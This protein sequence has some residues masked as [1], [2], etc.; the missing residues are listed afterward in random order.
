MEEKA[1]SGRLPRILPVFLVA[2]QVMFSFV[3]IVKNITVVPQYGDTTEYLG[4]SKTLALDKFRTILYPLFLKAVIHFSSLFQIP[5]QSVAY[6]FQMALSFAAVLYFFRTLLGLYIPQSRQGS[7]HRRLTQTALILSA[8]AFTNPLVTHFNLSVLTDSFALSF[9]VLF[10]GSVLRLYRSKSGSFLGLFT[11]LAFYTLMSLTRPERKLLGFAVLIVAASFEML[12]NRAFRDR[13]D[14]GFKKFVCVL[15]AAAIGFIL[16]GG[17]NSAT[18]TAAPTRN[19]PALYKS[20]FEFVV[21]PRLT[22]IY[23]SLPASIRR[24]ITYHDAVNNDAAPINTNNTIS[25]LLTHGHGSPSQI[26]EITKITFLRYCPEIIGTFFLDVG[27]N[28]V[29]PFCYVFNYFLND[30]NINWTNT[31]MS[32]AHPFFTRIY[33]IYS[34]ILFLLAA[35]AAVFGLFRRHSIG[36]LQKSVL[37]I[38]GIFMLIFSVFFTAVSDLGFHIRYAMP[39]YTVFIMIVYGLAALTILPV[40]MKKT[41]GG[42]KD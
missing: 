21:W 30:G 22:K 20:A 27:K 12:K 11:V 36:F 19:Q 23:P 25:K 34:K 32:M 38:I 8:F 26:N 28:M 39:M 35:V 15:A 2:L 1:D 24:V 31:R 17:I 5:Y 42:E 18:Q 13:A 29:S 9:T 7:E 14:A 37:E 4:L 40:Q 41:A 16:V 3:W 6:F 33:V 10:L